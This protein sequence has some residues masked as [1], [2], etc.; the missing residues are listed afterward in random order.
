M[1][2]SLIRGG[3]HHQA[4]L[5]HVGGYHHMR[6]VRVAALLVGDH[7]AHAVDGHVFLAQHAH[8]LLVN[9]GAHQFLTSADALQFTK[10]FQL[11]NASFHPS[12]RSPRKWA[13]SLPHSRITFMS[14]SSTVVCMYFSG[15]S[16]STHGTPSRAI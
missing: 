4:H 16:I 15:R 6:R 10:L 7:V 11:H 5:V 12:S 14:R 13:S 3:N 9:G 1:Q 8:A 2:K